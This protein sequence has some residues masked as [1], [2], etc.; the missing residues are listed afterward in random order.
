[1]S[2]FA[3]NEDFAD[4][5]SFYP[6][7]LSQMRWSSAAHAIP[8]SVNTTEAVLLSRSLR[9]ILKIA[10]NTL[11]TDIMYSLTCSNSTLNKTSSPAMEA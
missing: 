1:M 3:A 2:Y 8:Q 5:F 6:L 7:V 9:L 4:L 10:H 11:K